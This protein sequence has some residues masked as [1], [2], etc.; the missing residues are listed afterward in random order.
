MIYGSVSSGEVWFFGKLEGKT[1]FQDPR[2]FT[3]THLDEL[4]AALNYVFQQAKLEALS[5]TAGG[6]S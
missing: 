3:L 1:L 2:S 6:N 5:G 4:F